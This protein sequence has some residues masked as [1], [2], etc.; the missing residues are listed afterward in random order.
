VVREIELLTDARVTMLSDRRKTRPYGLKGGEPAEPGRTVLI[1][2]AGEHV[3]AGKDSVDAEAGDR[4]RIESPGG[5]GWG[6]ERKA[7]QGKP[8]KQ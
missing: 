2:T 8:H 5:G 6:S 1:T 7:R 3:M 4:I